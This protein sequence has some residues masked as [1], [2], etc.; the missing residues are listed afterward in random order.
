MLRLALLS[1]RRPVPTL[2]V[3]LA[4]AAALTVAGLGV[5][6]S[7]SPSVVTVP[8]S[9]SSRAQ[10]LADRQFG[11]SVLVPILLQGPAAQLD[12]QGPELVR[13]L[14]ARS[15]TRVMSAWDGGDAAKALRPAPGSAMIVASLA[16]SEKAMVNRYQAEIDRTVDFA[17][18]GSVRWHITGQPTLD[19]AL[20][21]S[22][23]SDTRRAELL[24]MALLFVLLLALLR[25]PVAAALVTAFGA[26]SVFMSFGLM[27]LLGQVIAID[28]IALALASISGL[29][30][31]IGFA[32]IVLR[33]FL[34]EE[35][36]RDPH[37][38][39]GAEQAAVAH[40]VATS[41]RSVLFG[42]T[43]LAVCLLLAV[44]I[45]PTT[46]VGSLGIGAVLC[47]LLAVGGA[48]VVLPAF[49]VLLGP[50]IDLG[51]FGLP[52]PLDRAW[53]RLVGAGSF[54]TA[55]A[56]WTGA[57][58]TAVLAALA[59]PAAGLKTGP[60]D[61]S[62]LPSGS[63]ARHDFET[64]A[65]VMGP[66]W[67]TPYNILVVS[68][69]RPITDTALLRSLD[70]Y[71]A[72]LA[73]DPRIASVAGPGAF[74]A[75]TK[76]LGKLPKTLKDS[77]KLLKGG[78]KQLGTLAS[79][80]GQ[81]AA[82]T[83]TLQAGLQS[84]AS[85][86]SQLQ[87]GS[88]TARNGAGQ[89]KAGIAKAR[90]G[91]LQ[92]SGGLDTALTGA[93]ALRA[94]AAKALAGSKQLTGGLGKAATPVKAG[95]PVVKQMAAD[96][97]SA[98]ASLGGLTGSASATTTSLDQAIASLQA[99]GNDPAVAAALAAVRSARDHASSV[100]SGLGTVQTQISGASGVATAFATQTSQLAGGLGQLLA[101]STALQ[102][103]IAQL[104]NGNA[105]L[106]TG[107]A[108][109]NTGGGQ[110]T[111]GLA[112]LQT[113]AGALEDGLGQL[114]SGAGQL[115]GGLSA[116]TAPAGQLT[117]GLLS[118]QSQVT[119]FR[120][121]LPS[122]KDLEELQKQSPGL[123]TNGYFTLAAIAGAPSSQARQAAFAVNL[124][125][126]GNAGQ[127]VV[128]P[129]Y[130]SKDERTQQLA[131]SLRDSAA[132]FGRQTH[133][134]TA[135]GGPAGNLADYHG[136]TA[137]RIWPV[138]ATLAVVVALML[139]AMLRTVVLPLVAVAFDLLAAAAAFGILSLLFTGSGAP[140]GGP[141]YLDP[142]IVVALFAASF[143]I[144]AFF[145]VA[146]LN[147]TREEFLRTGDAHRALR[148]GLRDTAGA[149]T[150]VAVAMVAAVVPFLFETIMQV[151]QI[152]IGL[153]AVVI[154]DGL[155]VRPVLLPAAVELFGRTAW[156]PTSRSAPGAA[157]AGELGSRPAPGPDLRPP[158]LAGGGRS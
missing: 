76:D 147:R 120:G 63:Q 107:I 2:L 151:R 121:Q 112:A 58:A 119:R 65:R 53:Q 37:I 139:M 132:A 7:L 138:V 158:T 91:A 89:L 149:V 10:T 28:P 73:M 105:D 17:L 35:G 36:L 57:A 101:G 69:S 148:A 9:E 50:R 109:L 157:Q 152:G 92:I 16:H 13:R 126:G 102:S 90:A 55:R 87:S 88:G 30:L 133:T 1:I 46:I 98:D 154:L 150:M 155:L 156:W 136:V 114:T 14:A 134:T 72:K 81:A 27:T 111:D 61:I 47:V 110:L 62:Q 99:A 24:A 125:R 45:A 33:R 20:K 83:K 135:V 68:S 82:G 25:R 71:Q 130:A 54:V 70:T 29:A 12:R 66:G 95:A 42:G 118:G 59:V 51:R 100:A 143:G 96:L 94:G 80:L 74:R 78:R 41:G 67:P 79:G 146:L 145:E 5:S 124:A 103:G 137:G 85:G 22:A 128:I 23:I 21:H 117:S 39:R 142:V 86:A 127:I 49:L 44:L 19:R 123:F 131:T 26:A 144:T 93:K 15:D 40:A 52:A 97:S 141:G 43:A 153:A 108:K 77:E 4:V 8:G 116:G 104:R 75:Q 106:D 129:R 115:A 60:P 34:D 31:G 11:P 38:G 32:L 64:V 140:L 48:V 18:S 122:A 3:W 84:A 6:H 113:G 56:V